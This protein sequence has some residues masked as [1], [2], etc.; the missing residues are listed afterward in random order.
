LASALTA[1]LGHGTGSTT[2]A[3][4]RYSN[5]AVETEF[6]ISNIAYSLGFVGL[7]MYLLLIFRTLKLAVHLAGAGRSFAM[8]GS[9]GL[10]TASALQWLNGAEYS[11]GPLV[12]L[13]I[14]FIWRSGEDSS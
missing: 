13:S 8:S 14:G 1:P 6:D 11:I 3:A 10:L 2:A 7:L 9:L 4:A 5:F 12:W